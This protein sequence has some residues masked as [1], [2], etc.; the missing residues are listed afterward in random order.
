MRSADFT[1]S[2][3]QAFKNKCISQNHFKLIAREKFEMIELMD[4]EFNVRAYFSHPPL[5]KQLDDNTNFD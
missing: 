1:V 4:S 2:D 5:D 3:Y